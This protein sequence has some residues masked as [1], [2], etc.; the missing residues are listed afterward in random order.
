MDCSVNRLMHDG[1]IQ[2]VITMRDA[3]QR[4]EHQENLRQA[5]LKAEEASRAKSDFLAV[6]SHEIRTP[7]NGILGMAQI[8][9]T[10]LADEEQRELSDLILSA[11]ESLLRVLDDV[12]DF[13]KLESGRFELE[14][15]G[16]VL[17]KVVQDVIGMMIGMAS[18]RCLLYTSPSPR[19][20]RQSRM[21]SSA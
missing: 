5:H 8:L 15:T 7:L 19:D 3:T 9:R 11:G 12:L 1:A 14:E 18:E 20:K 13:S 2:L 4:Y 16:F 17:R 6:M 21:P 10:D